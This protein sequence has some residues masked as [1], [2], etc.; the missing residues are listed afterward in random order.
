M[1]WWQPVLERCDNVRDF[2]SHRRVCRAALRASSGCIKM[3][4][5]VGAY[6]GLV[7]TRHRYDPATLQWTSDYDTTRLLKTVPLD[8]QVR[9]YCIKKRIKRSA[10]HVVGVQERLDHLAESRQRYVRQKA[11]L[12]EELTALQQAATAYRAK[13]RKPRIQLPNSKDDN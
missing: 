12:V 13:P 1:D 11:T 7:G 8:K 10:R 9:E 5:L 6:A 3:W 4:L 2:L